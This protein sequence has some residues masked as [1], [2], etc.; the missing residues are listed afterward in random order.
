MA[1]RALKIFIVENHD[2]TLTYLSKYLK[3]C[4]HEVQCAKGMGREWEIPSSLHFD[5]LI[6]NTGYRH[7]LNQSL[8]ARGTRRPDRRSRRGKIIL[9]PEIHVKRSP[10]A[11]S[12]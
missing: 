4:G 10:G 8:P 11:I 1:T 2:D 9:R 5:V 3:G 6:R 7:H 12:H